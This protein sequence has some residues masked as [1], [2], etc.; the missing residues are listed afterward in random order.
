MRQKVAGE[1][2]KQKM[3]MYSAHD[4]TLS[5]LLLGLGV[6]N[7]VAP[8]YATTVLIE[9][10]KIGEEHFVQVW[11]IHIVGVL[12]FRV[13]GSVFPFGYSDLGI[14][15]V[16]SLATCDRVYDEMQKKLDYGELFSFL[17]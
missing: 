1:I 5:I 8:P 4:I 14:L 3:Y 10:H 13:Y 9:L 6:F 7:N 15:N 16:K 17:F 11:N 12:N 2:P